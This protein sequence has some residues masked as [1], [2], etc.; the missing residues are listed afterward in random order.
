MTGYIYPLHIKSHLK[1]KYEYYMLLY[2]WINWLA[3]P[4]LRAWTQNQQENIDFHSTLYQ[5][6]I[7]TVA[8]HNNH[9]MSATYIYFY[10]CGAHLI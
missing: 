2:L 6:A 7:A 1:N 3:S 4:Y 8:L 10:F 9:K 5:L